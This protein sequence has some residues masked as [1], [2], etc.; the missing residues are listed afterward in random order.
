MNI[1]ET[2]ECSGQILSNSSGQ[3]EMTSQLSTT[4]L[5]LFSFMKDNSSILFWLKEYILYS[6]LAQ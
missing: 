1:F 4:F 2:S 3:F 5:S 6:K